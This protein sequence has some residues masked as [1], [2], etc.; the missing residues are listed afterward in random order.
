MNEGRQTR[1]LII[2]SCASRD[3]FALSPSPDFVI[4]DYYAR[5]SFAVLNAHPLVDH[6]L[7]ARIDSPFQRRMVLRDMD[8]SLL[9]ALRDDDFDLILLDFIDER[10]DILLR[11]SGDAVT[12]SPE[13][14]SGA[15]SAAG[16]MAGRR[17]VNSDP[18]R[19]DRWREGLIHFAT[20]IKARGWQER[21]VVNRVFWALTDQ[22]G[23]PIDEYP[24]AV[25]K[26]QNLLLAKMYDALAEALP[27]T[28]WLTYQTDSLLADHGHKWGLEPFHYQQSIYDT[29][30]SQLREIIQAGEI[31]GQNDP[32]SRHRPSAALHMPAAPG[33]TIQPGAQP[34]ALK[35]Q[36]LKQ[37]HTEDLMAESRSP[38]DEVKAHQPT[39][40]EPVVTSDEATPAAP[41][42]PFEVIEGDRSYRMVLPDSAT[43]YIQKGIAQTREPYER[44]MLRDMASRLSPGDLVL[45]IGANIG[46]HAMY[47]AVV[48]D[49][50]V[51][52]FEPNPH[53]V[54][55]IEQSIAENDLG[56]RLSIRKFGV[57][58]SAG[59]A[60]FGVERPENLGGQHLELGA[61]EIDVVTLDSQSFP[62]P[63]RAIK[64]DVEG[65]ESAV[66]AGAEDLI[67]R[68]QPILYV[69]CEN[70]AS[71]RAVLRLL[72]PLGYKYWDTF[73]ATPT[74]LF[75]PSALADQKDRLEQAG[76]RLAVESYRSGLELARL[77]KALSEA[78]TKYR[79]VSE[80]LQAAR[81]D[82]AAIR[83]AVESKTAALSGA[84]ADIKSLT[85]DYDRIQADLRDAKAKAQ[86]HAMDMAAAKTRREADQ[87]EIAELQSQ[88]V[89]VRSE[90]Q[91]RQ[92]EAETARQKLDAANT[93]Y[94][95]LT[96]RYDQTVPQLR[97]ALTMTER[98]L[99]EAQGQ[100]S[101]LRGR[102]V[103]MA[104]SRTYRAGEVLRDG[105]ASVR[106]F[107]AI[108]VRMARVFRTHL[109]S[110]PPGLLPPPVEAAPPARPGPV[111][112]PTSGPPPG[113]APQAASSTEVQAKAAAAPA[114]TAPIFRDG[115]APPEPLAAREGAARVA[116]ILLAPRKDLRVA[117]IMDDFTYTCFAPEADLLGLTA[118][119]WQ[120]E[121]E[122]FKPDLLFVESAWRGKNDSWDRK[123]G[124]RS[125]ELHDLVGWCRKNG[126]PT[127]FWNKEDPVHY[128]S[129]LSTAKLFDHVFTTDI[130]CIHLYR[131]A[132][133]HDR[134]WLLPFACQPRVHNPIELFARRDAINFAGAYYTRYPE[135]TRD[136]ENF[137]AGLPLLRPLDIFDRNWG[138]DDPNY[139]FPESFRTFIVGTLPASRIDVAYKGYRYAINLNSVKQSQSMFARRVYELLASG[140]VTISNFSRGLRMMFGDL[141][142][143]SDDHGEV[144]RRFEKVADQPGHADRLRLAGLRKIMSQHTSADRLA[145][146]VSKALPDRAPQADLPAVTVIAHAPDEESARHLLAAFTAQTHRDARLLLIAPEGFRAADH[147]PRVRLL[148]EG[149]APPDLTEELAAGWLACFSAKDYYGPNYLRDLVL[150][151]RYSGADVIGKAA[152]PTGDGT[153]MD[154]AAAYIPVAGIS[155][156]RGIIRGALLNEQDR[157]GLLDGIDTGDWRADRVLSV[158]PFNYCHEVADRTTIASVVDDLRGIDPGLPLPEILSRAESIK[159]ADMPATAR[160]LD[161][162]DLARLFRGQSAP[163]VQIVVSPIS[164]EVASELADG[165][166]AYIY[167]TTSLRP[168]EVLENGVLRCHV[169][170]SPGLSISFVMIWLDAKGSRLGHAMIHPLRNET[171]EPPAG[172]AS[173][174]LGLRVLGSGMCEIK[175]LDLTHRQLTPSTLLDRG[176]VLIVTNQYPAYSDLYRNAFLHSRV[177]RYAALGLRP[178]VLRFRESVAP[179]F[180]EFENTD[181]MTAD[182]VTL[183]KMLAEGGY[184][185]VAV[186]FLTPEVW[187]ILR[188]HLDRVRVVVWCHGVDIQPW[189]RRAFLY[190]TPAEREAAQRA[191]DARMAFW[192]GVLRPQHPNLKLVFVSQ[193]LADTAAEDLGISFVPGQIEV[194]HNPIDTGIFAYQPKKTEDRLK[195]LLL[196]PFASSVY[197]NDLAV[198]AIRILSAKPWFDQM[199]FRI[200]GDGPLLEETVAPLRGMDNVEIQKGFLSHTEIAGLHREAG[201]FLVPTR[202]DT[203]GVSRDEAMASGLVPVTTAVA[204][205]PEFVDETCG[206]LVPPDDAQAL[207]DAIER[208]YHEP[209][210]F[211]RLSEAA[212]RRVRAQSDADLMIEREISVLTS[213][214]T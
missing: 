192:H 140:T 180:T 133:R 9:A 25:A 209:D 32:S 62:G 39:R 138:R 19:Y 167:S 97:A 87:R 146:V 145:Y 134:V 184:D 106:G 6:A 195:V 3:I 22:S 165:K 212:A 77:K 15:D 29:A 75:L 122:G 84:L 24:A 172:T 85:A 187:D 76:L 119:N 124:H 98:R 81:K 116:D 205:V 162:R 40:A 52:A 118:G 43:D 198:A 30:I 83:S 123:I 71:F 196:R 183:D 200:A 80:Q 112:A 108:P 68:D 10:F 213:V 55:A 103:S 51:I 96:G 38:V 202:T 102:L 46:N 188:P 171:A 169:D 186:H 156:R 131:Q 57:G 189:T 204:A 4:S 130:D 26:R 11:A 49:C 161:N 89:G 151:T 17:L 91:K 207:A 197:A 5:S 42:G 44:E 66:L 35:S 59:R 47:L 88:L 170:V 160:R 201:I 64:I 73:N 135:R 206:I 31:A 178:S 50:R 34:I 111:A 168:S 127:V 13:F 150:A 211:L 166:H 41:D 137:T 82:T 7:L 125:Q 148:S 190:T 149:E 37:T 20:L 90:S 93:K 191:S 142:I 143:S 45:D 176:R 136:L 12:V 61:G 33:D 157:A 174:R 86:I 78:N 18:E 101:L 210:L 94:R 53:L 141:V 95:E 158:D 126:V 177:R 58:A 79:N 182:R 110:P 28:R 181:V 114:I 65:M 23:A 139:A 203:H 105:A 214:G 153:L 99:R 163:G 128:T 154:P 67:K 72:H 107:A 48:A 173:V 179:T 100:N 16:S 1:V 199:H 60:K 175:S 152:Y 74:H 185:T 120:S 70:E 155:R 14:L 117:A 121:I 147:D 8:K 208:L 109:D 92:I 2:G 104:N 194:I 144:T 56:E 69:E 21:L 54:E 132:L 164:F 193:Q 27:Q 63:V 113:E 36:G 159:P 129:F 115:Y